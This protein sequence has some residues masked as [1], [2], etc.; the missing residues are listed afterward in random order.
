MHQGQLVFAP[1]D[2]PLIERDPEVKRAV[3][4]LRT[5]SV[6]RHDAVSASARD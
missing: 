1:A 6:A 4:E 5:P 2:A 3:E